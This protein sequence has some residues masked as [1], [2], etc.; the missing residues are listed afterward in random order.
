M[1]R[2]LWLVFFGVLSCR[3]AAQEQIA[4]SFPLDPDASV[5]IVNLTDSGSIRIIGWDKDSVVVSGTVARGSRFWSGG[6]GRRDAIKMF[7]DADKGAV[8]K[9]AGRSELIVRLPAHAR[10]WVNAVVADVDVSALAGQLDVTAV[11]SHVRVLG[12]LTEL[13]AETMNGDV[14]VTASPA[15]LRLK[16]AT[17]RIT[18][19]GSS[20]DVAVTTVSGRIMIDAG[21]VHRARFESIDGDIRFT[22]G[23]SK[24]ASVTVDTHGG[25]VALVMSKDTEAWVESS[26]SA[27]DLFGKHSKGP[28]GRVSRET[29]YTSVG[30][31]SESA[32]RVVV[33]SFKGRVT[34]T[35]QR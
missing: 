28:R 11:S 22:G 14:E 2:S 24:A 3:L 29:N 1:H 16:T 17:G 33:R 34:A 7:V 8:G 25:D 23:V 19:T 35:L 18:W 5:R 6:G 32:A 9:S 26:G 12:T 30:K 20:E 10:V 27:S 13:R 31:P 21:T 4:R 15:Y